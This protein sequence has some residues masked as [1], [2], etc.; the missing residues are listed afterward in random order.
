MVFSPIIYDYSDEKQ[1]SDLMEVHKNKIQI[2]D[3]VYIV[4]KDYVIS[5]DMKNQVDYAQSLRKI[6]TYMEDKNAE[7]N[8]E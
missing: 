8:R 3:E 4:N 6:I 2:S 1:K 7:G 5:D